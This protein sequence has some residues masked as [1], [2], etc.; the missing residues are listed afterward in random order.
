MD[1]KLTFDNLLELLDDFASENDTNKT[2]AS[3]IRSRI[4]YGM[5]QNNFL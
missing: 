1:D 2:Y 5:L 4:T 3:T